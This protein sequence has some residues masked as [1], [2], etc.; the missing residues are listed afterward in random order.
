MCGWLF[1][2]VVIANFPRSMPIIEFFK[3]C[4]YLA[5]TWW[6]VF[7]THGVVDRGSDLLASAVC[8]LSLSH[9][10]PTVR[11]GLSGQSPGPIVRY[12]GEWMAA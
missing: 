3:I 8:R 5:N 7:L 10:R 12:R 6:H 4:Q 2:N 9:Y 1:N 11:N